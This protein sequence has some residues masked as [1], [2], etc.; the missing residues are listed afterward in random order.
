MNQTG[1]QIRPILPQDR[2]ATRRFMRTQ[3]GAEEVAVHGVLY[4]PHELPGFIAEQA[5]RWVGLVTYQVSDTQCE[6]VTLNSLVQGQGIG[7]ALIEAIK[8]TARQTGCHRLWLVT[9]N[10]NLNALHFYQKRGFILAALRPGAV[11]AA[12]LL[13][14]SIPLIGDFGIPIRDEI[15]LELEI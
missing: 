15:E 13:K 12:R 14:P 5:A 1:S 10:D 8:R 3:W 2:E 7:S 9:T 6:I 4:S 11:N